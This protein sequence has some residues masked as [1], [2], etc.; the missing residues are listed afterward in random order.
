[1]DAFENMKTRRSVRQYAPETVDKTTIEDI[2]DCARL[3][4]SARNVQPW[5]FIVI[6]QTD[7]RQRLA[8]LAPNGPHIANA[9]VCIAV[10]C[11]EG[12]YYLEDGS[13]A[14]Q[15]ILLAAHA[16]GLGSCW[17]AGDKKPY[18]E[19]VLCLLGVPPGNKLVSLISI[20][21]AATVCPTPEK[22]LLAD[23]IHWERF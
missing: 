7:I 10:V 23:V 9:P 16:H 11:A 13:A 6:T 8:A 19:D 1:M 21:R 14:T 4:A 20:G 3:A 15:N 17:I 5:E 22:R 12:T 2:I 18:A